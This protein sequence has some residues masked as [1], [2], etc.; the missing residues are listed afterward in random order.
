MTIAEPT[1]TKLTVPEEVKTNVQVELSDN[2]GTTNDPTKNRIALTD[3]VVKNVTCEENNKVD[4]K[5]TDT[6]K[7]QTCNVHDDGTK[8]DGTNDNVEVINDGIQKMTGV[9]TMKVNSEITQTKTN[10]TCNVDVL[11]DCNKEE[12][13]RPVLILMLT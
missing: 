9:E 5:I 6:Q 10:Q 8:H 1:V 4:S 11:I 7:N 2:E 12:I 3:S 13:K